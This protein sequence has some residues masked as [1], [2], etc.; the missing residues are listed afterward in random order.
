MVPS[1]LYLPPTRLPIYV[2][3]IKA[4][5]WFLYQIITY[6]SL[7]FAVV[8]SQASRPSCPVAIIQPPTHCEFLGLATIGQALLVRHRPED[9]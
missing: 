8:A 7:C 3:W 4:L 5:L 1:R 6:F 9:H 2:A